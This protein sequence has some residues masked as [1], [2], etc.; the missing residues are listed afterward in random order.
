[1]IYSLKSSLRGGGSI[2]MIT[3]EEFI[4]YI[5]NVKRIN[6]LTHTLYQLDIDIINLETTDSDVI[7]LLDKMFNT[8]LISYWCWEIDF[9]KEPLITYDTNGTELYRINTI[10]E[11]YDKAVEEYENK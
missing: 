3:K 6:N 5:N 1:M 7:E 8:T 4:R 11:L 10:E 9:G 2:K